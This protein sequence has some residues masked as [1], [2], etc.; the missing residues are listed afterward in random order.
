[1]LVVI[2]IILTV[3]ICVQTYQYKVLLN[4]YIC[5]TSSINHCF[6]SLCIQNGIKDGQFAAIDKNIIYFNDLHCLLHFIASAKPLI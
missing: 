2:I 5:G 1:M 6:E 3:Y 4:R